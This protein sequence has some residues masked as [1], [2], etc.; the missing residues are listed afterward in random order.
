MF[1]V[2]VGSIRGKLIDGR[3]IPQAN[4]GRLNAE[5]VS[6]VQ[7]VPESQTTRGMASILRSMNKCLLYFCI[8][9]RASA[10]SHPGQDAGPGALWG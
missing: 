1:K 3:S 7:E 10:V 4:Q 5:V 6:T 8:A 9:S 2:C